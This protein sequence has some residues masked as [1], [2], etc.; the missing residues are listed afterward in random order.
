MAGSESVANTLTVQVEGRDLPPDVSAL[1]VHALVDDSTQLPDMFVLRFTDPDTTVLQKGG[2][3]IGKAVSLS[4]RRSESPGAEPLLE[5]EI[6]SL[7]TVHTHHGTQTVVR[8][9][10]KSHRLFHGHR[11][12]VYQQMKLSDIVGDVGR[13][14]GLRTDVDASQAVFEYVLQDGVSDWDFLRR[15]ARQANRSLSVVKSQ[16]LFKAPVEASA[17]PSSTASRDNPQV[18]EVGVNVVHLRTTL[19]ASDQ[20]SGVQVRSWDPKAK[21][22]LVATATPRGDTAKIGAGAPSALLS[23]F[24]SSTY[25]AHEA[26]LQ[27]QTALQATADSLAGHLSGGFAELEGA[28]HGNAALRAGAPVN[29]QRVGDKFNGKYVLTSTRHEFGADS[30]YQTSFTASDRSER[31][32]L[33]IATGATTSH[34]TAALSGVGVGLVTNLNDPDALGRVRV[35]FPLLSE[36]KE[37]WW[38]RVVQLGAGAS[39]GTV[40]LP[41]IGDEVLVAFGQDDAQQPFVIGGLYNGRDKPDTAW[42]TVQE[43][44]EVRR[45]A[46]VSRKKMLLEFIETPQDEKLTVSTNAGTQRITLVQNADKGIE[47]LSE[48]PLTVTAKKDVKV[49]GQ[50]KV[51]VSAMQDVSVTSSSGAINV[52]TSGGNV[53]LKG[54]NVTIEATAKLDLKGATAS[55]AGQASTEVKSSAITNITGS[56]VKI[57]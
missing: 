18:I 56:I 57:N 40:W 21:R 10:D 24:G 30:G 14:A 7:E 43:Q 54:L 11:V 3:D 25:V 28:V 46:F 29:V 6:T 19:T 15:L 17:A 22:A 52:E 36:D 26:G 23:D 16:L 4:V 41:E 35:K 45:R 53:T 44:G 48:G 31:S 13:R 1:M 2:F 49:T 50:Q 39:R 32:L 37:S 12:E 8:G 38:A 5:G 20:A 42:T 33:G 9:F 27:T 47:I 51:E 55:L 34:P